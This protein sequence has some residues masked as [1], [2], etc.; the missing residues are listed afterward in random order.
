MPELAFVS[1]LLTIAAVTIVALAVVGS[2]RRRPPVRP[3]STGSHRR[4]TLPTPG[5]ALR[6]AR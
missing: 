1:L 3:Q 5:R 2:A 4:A 6:S